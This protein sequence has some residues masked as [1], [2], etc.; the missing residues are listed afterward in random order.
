MQWRRKAGGTKFTDGLKKCSEKWDDP[1]KTLEKSDDK[2]E[3]KQADLTKPTNSDEKEKK[4]GRR[5]VK[6]PFYSAEM[7]G[8]VLSHYR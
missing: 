1:V 3:E 8:R 6:K 7:R 4:P 5:G 2:G